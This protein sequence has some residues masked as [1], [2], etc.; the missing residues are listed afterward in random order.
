MVK[1]IKTLEIKR[2]FLNLI[3][4]IYRKPNLTVNGE[5]IDAFPLRWRISQRCFLS[6]LLFAI[7]LKVLA[8]AIRQKKNDIK[9]T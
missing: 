3:K 4:N 9:G 5:K 2:N 7:I 8:N 6:P 1:I